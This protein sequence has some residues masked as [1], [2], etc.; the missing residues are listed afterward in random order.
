MLNEVPLHGYNGPCLPSV[1]IMPVHCSVQ[2]Q[3]ARPSGPD[4]QLPSFLQR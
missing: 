3:M 1:Q 4:A 2:I